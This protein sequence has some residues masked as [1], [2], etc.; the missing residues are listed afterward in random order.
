MFSFLIRNKV[1]SIDV[2]ELDENL[3]KNKLID[4]REPYE[5]KLGTIKGAKKV[6]MNTLLKD[7]DK[8]LNKEDEYYIMCQSG[9]RSSRTS[10]TLSKLGFKVVNVKG[11]FGSYVEKG[12]KR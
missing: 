3:I 8:Y 2:N 4:I 5:T 12:A 11:G 9:M 7:P 1:K 6:P 10:K